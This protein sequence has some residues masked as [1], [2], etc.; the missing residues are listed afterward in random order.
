MLRERE[1]RARAL[2]RA[3]LGG[4]AP[5]PGRFAPERRWACGSRLAMARGPLK[6]MGRWPAR[7]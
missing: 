2:R 4:S 1:P 3:T 5:E 7:A 6:V